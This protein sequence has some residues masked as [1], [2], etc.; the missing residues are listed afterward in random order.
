MTSLQRRWE[1]SLAER[2]R[3][4]G[5]SPVPILNE[6]LGHAAREPGPAIRVLSA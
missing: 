4:G 3:F 6:L 5:S 2:L 1:S